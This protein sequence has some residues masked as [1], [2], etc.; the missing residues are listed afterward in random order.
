M[1]NINR[2]KT[3]RIEEYLKF[4]EEIFNFVLGRRV[5]KYIL[6]YFGVISVV[7]LLGGNSYIKYVAKAEVDRVIARE[8]GEEHTYLRAVNQITEFGNLVITTGKV[9]YY[10]AI[11][12]FISSEKQ[13]RIVNAAKAELM[14]IENFFV[15]SGDEN[16]PTDDV[17]CSAPSGELLKGHKVPTKNLIEMFDNTEQ[18]G[19]K[20]TILE[21]LWH[22]REK[23]VPEF[24]LK[25]ARNTDY[26]RIRYVALQGLQIELDSFST[27]PFDLEANEVLWERSKDDFEKALLPK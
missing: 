13:E 23:G 24:F 8:I 21:I 3:N 16:Y 7:L 2:R 25:T 15:W 1:K 6:S 20:T 4:K 11:K 14:R 27:N 9:A 18:F 19:K 17:E 5:H 10:N 22:R 26:L 12:E